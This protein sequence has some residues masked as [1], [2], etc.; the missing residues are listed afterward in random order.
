MSGLLVAPGEPNELAQALERLVREPVLRQHLAA[1]AE[2]T[3]RTHFSYEAGVDWIA[4]AL[5]QHRRSEARAAE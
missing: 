2:H 1:R 3:V 4:L 5:G